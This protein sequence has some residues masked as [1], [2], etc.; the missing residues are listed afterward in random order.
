MR[1]LTFDQRRTH[2][3]GPLYPSILR[4]RKELR[5]REP[6]AIVL[7]APADADLGVYVN[8]YLYPHPTRMYFGTAAYRADPHAPRTIA[9]IDREQAWEVRRLR[10]PLP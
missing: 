2:M 8:H 6:V 3:L 9:Y 10:G 5:P 7:H 1:L 4:L